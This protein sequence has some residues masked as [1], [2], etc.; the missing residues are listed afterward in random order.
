MDIGPLSGL[1]GEW[2]LAVD[3]P[4][5]EDVLGHVVFEAMGDV[6][7]QRTTVP[8]PEAPDSCCVVVTADDGSYVQ[9]YFD[10]R[11]VARLYAMTFDGHTWTLERS[12]PDFAPLEFHQR[13]IGAVSDD[14]GTITGEWQSSADGQQWTRDFGLVHTRR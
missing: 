6:L 5:A 12:K 10:S 13:Y 7:V 11:G 2:D 4:G 1:V 3:L 8:V 9:H 14:G